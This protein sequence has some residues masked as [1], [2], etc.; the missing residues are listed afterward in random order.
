E[1]QRSHRQPWRVVSECQLGATPAFCGFSRR[2]GAPVGAEML[3][4]ASVNGLFRCWSAEDLPTEP[5][6]SPPVVPAVA[7]SAAAMTG[8]AVATA[9]GQ[10]KEEEELEARAAVPT[11]QPL[12]LP[13][14]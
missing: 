11:P 1:Q 4:A 2:L 13:E 3:L 10:Q 6:P 9:A 12:P 5:V 7:T 14:D 8:A